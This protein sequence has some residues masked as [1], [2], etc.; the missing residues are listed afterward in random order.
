MKV[1]VFSFLEGIGHWN[2]TPQDVIE[3]WQQYLNQYRNYIIQF[4]P[5]N[6]RIDIVGEFP[7][8]T[9][10]DKVPIVEACR[11][12]ILK[13]PRSE[14]FYWKWEINYDDLPENKRPKKIEPAL[15]RLASRQ[16]GY[17]YHASSNSSSSVSGSGSFVSVSLTNTTAK[18]TR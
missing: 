18:R 17:S 9:A 3:A 13:M 10:A 4:N 2:V 11:N 7:G 12:V 16:S 1:I 8:V 5:H 15:E 14:G 6:N